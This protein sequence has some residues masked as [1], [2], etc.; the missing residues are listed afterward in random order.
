MPIALRETITVKYAGEDGWVISSRFDY[1]ADG[2]DK[3]G[4]T[5]AQVLGIKRG[6]QV[7]EDRSRHQMV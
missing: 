5:V 1:P 3:L 4:K 7:A 2:E 6:R